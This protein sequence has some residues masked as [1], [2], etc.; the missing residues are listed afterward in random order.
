MELKDVKRTHT[1]GK[2]G[3]KGD[4]PVIRLRNT[5]IAKLGWKSHY[6]SAQAVKATIAALLADPRVSP[7]E[8]SKQ[9]AAPVVVGRRSPESQR[10]WFVTGGAGFIGSHVVDLL[11]SAGQTVT[12][13]DNLSLSTDQY[14]AG[15]RARRARSRSTRRICSIS[16][17]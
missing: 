11:V 12:V 1:P 4:V 16:T 3:W 17:R 8:A 14:I 7:K 9:S 10:R 6:T 13:Y 2:I 5:R 15:L